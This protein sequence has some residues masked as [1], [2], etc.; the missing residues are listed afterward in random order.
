MGVAGGQQQKPRQTVA[1]SSPALVEAPC[2]TWDVSPG[3]LPPPC[4]PG[5]QVLWHF[6]HTSEMDLLLLVVGSCFSGSRWPLQDSGLLLGGL[7]RHG[8]T[9]LSAWKHS[10]S[11]GSE[12]L[13][14][15]PLPQVLPS[16]APVLGCLEMP[17]QLG[18]LPVSH[19]VPGHAVSPQAPHLNVPVLEEPVCMLLGSHQL[20][21][22]AL[23]CWFPLPGQS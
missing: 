9:T 12:Q 18:W 5:H 7:C 2:H 14:H 11:S 23:R 17:A 8:V 1:V 22:D 16:H 6:P 4:L 20:C 10:L 19:S 15:P 3:L 21:L 13:P